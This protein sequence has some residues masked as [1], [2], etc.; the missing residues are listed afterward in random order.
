MFFQC[1]SALVACV[2]DGGRSFIWY[3]LNLAIKS[4]VVAS[5]GRVLAKCF[6]RNK[7]LAQDADLCKVTSPTFAVFSIESLSANLFNKYLAAALKK[8]LNSTLKL[9]QIS[10]LEI[11]F[12]PLTHKHIVGMFACVYIACAPTALLLEIL[13]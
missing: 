4:S 6:T 3:M 1:S 10:R 9:V 12:H 8:I 5:L 13:S 2:A 11:V 7:M